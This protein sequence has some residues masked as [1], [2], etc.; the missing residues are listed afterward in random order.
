MSNEYGM[1]GKWLQLLKQ[2]VPG[3]TRYIYPDRLA[4]EVM[5][6]REAFS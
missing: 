6:S 4:G 5:P 3:L 2:V 1:S